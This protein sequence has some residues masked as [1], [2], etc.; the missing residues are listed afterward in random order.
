MNTP[1]SPNQSYHPF[2]IVLLAF[3]FLKKPESA[4]LKIAEDGLINC[5]LAAN[6]PR[7]EVA[8]GILARMQEF[9]LIEKIED[10]GGV[11]YKRTAEGILRTP[12]T[13][14]GQMPWTPEN[15]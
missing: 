8:L 15:N 3:E 12:K 14:A 10:S 11:S 5:M 7:Q 6:C 2:Q 1:H 4:E 13:S 9:G